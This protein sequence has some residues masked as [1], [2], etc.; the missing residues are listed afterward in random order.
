MA[1]SIEDKGDRGN[2]TTRSPGLV[3]QARGNPLAL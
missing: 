1:L 2:D 3:P